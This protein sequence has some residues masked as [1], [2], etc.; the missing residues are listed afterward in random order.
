VQVRKLFMTVAALVLG[1]WSFTAA[2][3]AGEAQPSTTDKANPAQAVQQGSH[4]CA[5]GMMRDAQGNCAPSTGAVPATQHQQEVL[6][7]AGGS[8]EE[9]QKKSQ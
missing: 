3:A 1:G 6:K 5:A 8:K 4:D 2:M 7:E 9:Q